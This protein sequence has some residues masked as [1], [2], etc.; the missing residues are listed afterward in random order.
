[1]KPTSS[2]LLTRVCDL[3]REFIS[4]YYPAELVYFPLIWEQ[5]EPLLQGGNLLISGKPTGRSGSIGFPF[6]RGREIRLTSPS[7]VSVVYSMLYQLDQRE[8][9]CTLSEIEAALKQTA[10]ALGAS[11]SLVKNLQLGLSRKLSTKESESGLHVEWFWQ[12]EQHKSS[13]FS[14]EDLDSLLLKHSFDTIIN[15][16]S[17]TLKI[18]PA[19]SRPL[20]EVARVYRGMLWLIITKIEEGVSHTE[21]ARLFRWSGDLDKR[22]NRIHQY[23]SRM[24]RFLGKRLA[25]SIFNK[26]YNRAYSIKKEGWSFCWVRASNTRSVLLHDFKDLN[27]GNQ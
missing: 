16:I 15:E 26:G 21:I 5:C 17:G 12:G 19:P 27:Q 10:E 18:G 4:E 9:V 2:H 22:R 14:K 8:V 25:S 24:N 11:R 7:V 3:S 6:D 13:G 23:R 1:M 20:L